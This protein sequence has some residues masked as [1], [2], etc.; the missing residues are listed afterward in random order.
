MK[1][2]VDPSLF[3]DGQEEYPDWGPVFL[4]AASKAML[5]NWYRKAQRLRA[6]KRGNKRKEKVVKAISD[7]E[8]ED[9]PKEWLRDM[10]NITAATKAIAVK[11]MR[12]ARARLQKKHGK[13]SGLRES[14]REAEEQGAAG[15][16]FRS[17]RKS[18]TLR[19]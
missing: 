14:E 7:D 15:E 18:R 16:T 19:K 11:W 17:G 6:G 12:T 1:G 13:G 2:V 9:L 5:L 8:G 4:T 3:D 10:P